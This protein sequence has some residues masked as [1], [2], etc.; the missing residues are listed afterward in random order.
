MVMSN[1]RLIGRFRHCTGMCSPVC[2]RSIGQTIL[3]LK[4]LPAA[5]DE[6]LGYCIQPNGPVANDLRNHPAMPLEM[7]I[8]TGVMLVSP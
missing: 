2:C 8:A 6:L 7:L 3:L 5:S 1:G 4:I